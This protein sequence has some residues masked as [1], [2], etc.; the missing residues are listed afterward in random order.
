MYFFP[1]C[2]LSITARHLPHLT[3]L[4]F[5]PAACESL[6]CTISGGQ[7]REKANKQSLLP[8][9]M[10]SKGGTGARR[11]HGGGGVQGRGLCGRRLKTVALS[12]RDLCIPLAEVKQIDPGCRFTRAFAP[13]PVKPPSPVASNQCSSPLIRPLFLSLRLSV[14]VCV[15]VCACVTPTPP[16]QAWIRRNTSENLWLTWSRI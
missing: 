13:L 9:F 15:R 3:S 7:W 1:D 2:I 14:R 10:F 4:L 12:R 5:S 16:R 8:E 11:R 6:P